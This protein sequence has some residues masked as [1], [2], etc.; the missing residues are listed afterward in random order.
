LIKNFVSYVKIVVLI[1]S[2]FSG[3]QKDCSPAIWAGVDFLLAGATSVATIDD[4][5]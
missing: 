3:Y 1:I 2:S 4:G 5:I